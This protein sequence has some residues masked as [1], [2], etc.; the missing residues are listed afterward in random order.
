M[1]SNLQDSWFYSAEPKS[2][3]KD[4]HSKNM[5][6]C[7]DQGRLPMGL[8]LCEAMCMHAHSAIADVQEYETWQFKGVAL[9]GGIAGARRL[10]H[11]WRSSWWASTL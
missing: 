11:T 10:P 4:H 5:A 8:V 9:S 2:N 3:G 7:W 1:P 6:L